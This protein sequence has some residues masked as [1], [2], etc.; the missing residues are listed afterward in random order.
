MPPNSLPPKPLPTWTIADFDCGDE[1][2]APPQVTT[3]ARV[4]GDIA[5]TRAWG[6][7]CKTILKARGADAGRYGL[8]KQ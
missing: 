4:E 6:R 3:K 7:S 1:P 5:D 8:V 2:E